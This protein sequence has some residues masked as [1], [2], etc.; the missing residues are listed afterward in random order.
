MKKRRK[1]I[2]IKGLRNGLMTLESFPLFRSKGKAIDFIND[3]LYKHEMK[4][5]RD[6]KDSYNII[7][8]EGDYITGDVTEG[9]KGKTGASL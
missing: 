8:R 6:K 3:E 1:I 4:A 5:V 2:E 9:D 7:K